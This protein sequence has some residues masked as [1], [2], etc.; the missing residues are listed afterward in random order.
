MNKQHPI[1]G[2]LRFGF[3]NNV[4][5]RPG[6]RSFKVFRQFGPRRAEALLFMRWG[7]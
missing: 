5:L 4:I 1:A 3:W 7:F 2:C 6:M